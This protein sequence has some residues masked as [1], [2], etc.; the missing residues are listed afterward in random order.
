MPG[1]SPRDTAPLVLVIDDVEDNRDVYA[2]FLGHEGWRVATAADGVAG[3]TMAARL[4]PSVIVLDLGL[5]LI[6]GW[7]V[8]AA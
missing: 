8:P 6:D 4:S 5:P 1:P 2:Q 3:L 7:E